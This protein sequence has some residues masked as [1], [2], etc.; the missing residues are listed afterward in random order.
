M[1]SVLVKAEAVSM[2]MR[3]RNGPQRAR[4][5]ASVM[6]PQY[7]VVGG[8]IPLTQLIE[9]PITRVGDG[10]EAPQWALERWV[11][12]FQDFPVVRKWN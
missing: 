4:Y 2:D 7:A 12:D 11:V 9:C 3:C 8:G 10:G 6:H 5:G 1:L